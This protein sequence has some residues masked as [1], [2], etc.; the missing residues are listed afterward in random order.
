MGGLHGANRLGGSAGLEILVF[1]RRAGESCAADAKNV[2]SVCEGWD[3]WAKGCIE[4]RDGSGDAETLRRQMQ[5]SLAFGAGV[6]RTDEQLK[7]AI[8]RLE[9]VVEQ[10][11]A[12]PGT[13]DAAG[14]TRL[15][16]INDAKTAL[17]VCKS[18]FERKESLGCHTLTDNNHVM[19]TPYRVIVSRIGTVRETIG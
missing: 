8:D 16:L 14:F 6:L 13:N 15:R 12:L 1:G 18:A 5:E 10:A 2:I 7:T 9:E 19:E 11:K 17:L 4:N 3:E